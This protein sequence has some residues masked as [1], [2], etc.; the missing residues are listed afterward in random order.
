MG[1]LKSLELSDPEPTSAPKR[2]S[3]NEVSR[4]RSIGSRAWIW[5]VLVVLALAGFWYYRTAHSKTSQDSGA[6]GAPGIDGGADCLITVEFVVAG[7]RVGDQSCGPVDVVAWSI[8]LSGIIGTGGG[9]DMSL[10]PTGL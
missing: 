3:A 1:H 2:T 6:A 9:G 8:V 4:S 5:V 10:P 7:A